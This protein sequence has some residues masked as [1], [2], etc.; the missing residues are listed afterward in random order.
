MTPFRRFDPAVSCV[1]H[2]ACP[3][4]RHNATRFD[5]LVDEL[6][7]NLIGFILLCLFIPVAWGVFV[8]WLFGL[9]YR[10]QKNTKDNEPVFPDYQ[11]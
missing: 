5:F 10:N 2:R 8:N 1:L 3:T 11:I 9:W 7:L 4:V 6:L